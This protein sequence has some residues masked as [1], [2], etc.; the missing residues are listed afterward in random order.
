MPASCE[1]S[2][3]FTDT[4][5]LKMYINGLNISAANHTSLEFLLKAVEVSKCEQNF[6]VNSFGN[7]VPV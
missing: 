4:R 7:F 1:R 2:L 5:V 6:L 3:K